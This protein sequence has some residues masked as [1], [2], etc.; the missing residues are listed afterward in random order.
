MEEITQEKE[1]EVFKQEKVQ[2]KQGPVFDMSKLDKKS[3]EILEET[4]EDDYKFKL[5]DFEGP[6]DLLLHLIKITKIDIRDI[7]LSNITEQYL[8]I[9]KDI[10][11]VDV[12]KASEFIN[13]SA[14]L[15]EIK[16]KHLLPRE[17]E[18]DAEEDLIRQIEERKVY[19]EE[20]KLIK[21]QCQ[22]LAELEDVN[23]FFKEPDDTVGEFKY[24]LPDK[25]SVDAMINALS[26]LMQK[27]TVKAEVI[28]EKK[29]VK[30]RFTVAQKIS[31]IKDYLVENKRFKFSD[32][33][34]DGYSRSEVINTFLALLE[35]LK[36]QYITVTQN[37]LFDDID[38][39]RNDDVSAR[40]TEDGVSEFDGEK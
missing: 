21:V 30:D 36:R 6:L 17:E 11:E 5:N 29:I 24:E 22:K 32:V 33:F 3:L 38:I 4:E 12:E 27:M 35:L 28:Q 37:N 23:K 18:F 7:F 40:L 8:E 1:Q 14:T 15:L 9:M 13:M 20:Y 2:E 34:D 10:D 31:Q 39:V 19:Q 25:L 26:N 16:S